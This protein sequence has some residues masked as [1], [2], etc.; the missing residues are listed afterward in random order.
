MGLL[1]G[2]EKKTPQI[3]ISNMTRIFLPMGLNVQTLLKIVITGRLLQLA[4]TL[5]ENILVA[6]E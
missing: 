6:I 3:K 5:Q 4:K 1:I 2:I